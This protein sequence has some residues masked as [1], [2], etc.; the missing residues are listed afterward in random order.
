MNEHQVEFENAVPLTLKTPSIYR[1]EL[2][3]VLLNLLT[4]ALKAVHGY[5][6]RRIRIEGF[7]SSD[8]YFVLR[9]INTGKKAPREKWDD[10]FR[11]F[12]TDSISDS[13]LGVGTGL[14]LSIVRDTV[15]EYAGLAKFI[16]VEDP[17]QTCV[18]IR[19]PLTGQ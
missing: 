13:G 14:G 5:P 16:E 11:P 2:Y 19:F 12:V 18:E 9:V 10:Y 1:A 6:E 4:N 7:K 17:W 15:N 8:N 3:S